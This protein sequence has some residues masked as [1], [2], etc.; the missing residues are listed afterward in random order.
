MYYILCFL[1]LLSGSAYSKIFSTADLQRVEEEI[2]EPD[3]EVLVLFDVDCTLIVPKDA[4]LRPAADDFLE[5][6]LGGGKVLDLP[7]GRRYVFREILMKAPQALV[8]ERS[9]GLIQ[10]L[11]E[12]GVPVIALTVTPRGKVG[13]VE[14]VADWRI[15]ELKRFGYDF[16]PSFAE[17]G[18]LE[19]PRDPDKDFSP[20]FK[21]GILFTSLHSKGATL[22]NFLRTTGYKPKRVIFIDDQMDYIESVARAAEDLGIDYT[23][24][25]YT[26][27]AELPCVVDRELG[28]F[29]VRYFLEHGEWKTDL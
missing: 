10:R 19:L 12:R 25:H 29:Q 3:G 9:L 28:A 13:D 22:K 17:V 21:S 15:A 14:S 1:L 18:V 7:T 6:L 27:A 2:G 24:V 4:I 8:D 5:E 20:L 26:A 11:Q 16:S 23:G